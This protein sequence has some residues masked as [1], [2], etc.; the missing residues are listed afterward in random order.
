[1]VEIDTSLHCLPEKNDDRRASGS[2]KQ[3]ENHAAEWDH[4]GRW[5]PPIHCCGFF[6]SPD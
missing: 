2:E 1:M 3:T 4:C 6:R 5:L